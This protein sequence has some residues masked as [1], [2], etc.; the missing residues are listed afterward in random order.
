MA[1]I[2]DRLNGAGINYTLTLDEVTKTNRS[3]NTT[4]S[5]SGEF[6]EVFLS[7]GSIYFNGTSDFLTANTNGISP[8][9]SFVSFNSFTIEFWVNPYNTGTNRPLFDNR[10]P[11]VVDQGLDI[12]LSSTNTVIVGSTATTYITGTT[13]LP[14]YSWN[15]IAL[16]RNVNSIILYVNGVQT[17]ATYTASETQNFTNSSIK[18]GYGAQANYFNGYISNYRIVQS[19]VYTSNFTPAPTQLLPVKYP[20][21]AVG[22][23]YMPSATGI[24]NCVATSTP[25]K[26][27]FTLEFWVYLDTASIPT[28]TSYYFVG[29][30][31]SGGTNSGPIIYDNG[32]FIKQGGGGFTNTGTI[33]S[34]RRWNHLAYVSLGTGVNQ[35]SFYLNGVLQATGDFP[36]TMHGGQTF[37]IGSVQNG[38]GSGV[39]PAYYS[40]FRIVQGQALYSG[41]SF[42]PP[43]GPLTMPAGA[44]GLL[45]NFNR[46]LGF[47]SDAN[48][49][50]ATIVGNGAIVSATANPNDKNILLLPTPYGTSGDFLPHS[51]ERTNVTILKPSSSTST[52]YYPLRDGSDNYFGSLSFDGSTQYLTTGTSSSYSFGTGD[53]TVEFWM[54]LNTL[55]ASKYTIIDFRLA[56]GATPHTIFV[57]STGFLGFYN[58]T[59]DVTSTTAPVSVKTWYH[60]AYSRVSGT[61]RI[62]VSGVQAYSAANVIDYGSSNKLT[63]GASVA[64]QAGEFVN[65]YL[66]NIKMVKGTGLYSSQFKPPIIP[67]SLS[68]N[69]VLLLKTPAS[70]NYITDSN[71]TPAI[72]TNNGSIKANT[73][74]PIVSTLGSAYFE[75]TSSYVKLQSSFT[76]ATST[77]P[78]TIE[79]WI[80]P[81]SFNSVT[82]I[83]V[84][85]AGAGGYIGFGFAS[86]ATGGTPNTVGDKPYFGTFSGWEVIAGTTSA[87]ANTWYHMAAVYNGT[88]TTLYVNGANVAANTITTANYN[89]YTSGTN[90]FLLGRRWDTVT[91]GIYFNGYISD[92]RVV[93]GVAVYTG[94]FTLLDRPLRISEP[95][96]TNVAAV[97]AA[98][99]DI[100]LNTPY[101]PNIGDNSNSFFI[102]TGSNNYVTTSTVSGVI[103]ANSSTNSP[104]LGIGPVNKQI[105]V[106]RISNTNTRIVTQTYGFIDEV[107]TIV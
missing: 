107:T 28:G 69:T 73:F 21:T 79:A 106:R 34:P 16:V 49:T 88:M 105:P 1:T 38:S 32:G 25:W 56:N 82:A 42:T 97:S 11:D 65:G 19:A 20:E 39:R 4:N 7:P 31:G 22:S 57:S 93:K 17:G 44:Y 83:S 37:G 23:V 63:I 53:Y 8:A 59:A 100:L 29:N 12:Y 78:F 92:F 85:D 14:L 94:N 74:N 18:I 58:G 60:I 64:Q 72:L 62:Y 96:R 35:F 98:Q 81:M 24:Y 101:Y 99:T 66:S 40:N 3:L 9:D 26:N 87:V 36:Y 48:T 47:L 55:P 70:N 30:G 67:L 80:K 43:T 6:D 41:S 45:L 102:N 95:A 27:I 13:V 54:Y 68:T 90:S 15:H 89:H 33:P 51:S 103:A 75:G 91:P 77:T 46:G 84:G 2:V 50:P 52:N 104:F 71:T 86:V 76:L 61:L 10:S 5:F